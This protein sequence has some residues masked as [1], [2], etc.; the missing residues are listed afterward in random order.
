[1]LWALLVPGR[2]EAQSPSQAGPKPT[3]VARPRA[4]FRSKRR[5]ARWKRFDNSF[6]RS[7]L[8]VIRV[9]KPFSYKTP[10]RASRIW[11]MTWAAGPRAGAA[12]Q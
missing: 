5:H 4:G 8:P 9:P 3:S 2:A 1:M 7:P 12:G 10:E 11:L 6:A